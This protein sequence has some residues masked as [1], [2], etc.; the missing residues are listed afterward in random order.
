MVRHKNVHSPQPDPDESARRNLILLV[1]VLTVMLV[2]V[3]WI[4]KMGLSGP[5]PG[6]PAEVA[7]AAPEPP[8]EPVAP[9]PAPT[10]ARVRRSAARKP[11]PAPAPAPRPATLEEHW[12]IQVDSLR[13]S[14]GN[15]IV[16]LRYKILD[17]AKAAQLANGKTPSYII[18]RATGTKLIMPTPP[19]EGAFPPTSHKLVAGKT[20]FSM[21]SN[22]G[23]TLKSGSQ[24][25]V[26]VGG[27]EATNLTLE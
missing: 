9:T 2:A 15:S 1:G 19:K 5:S 14:M 11:A 27:S 13:L 10:V 16:D 6:A 26:V 23:G 17:P 18:D 7:D 20:Y 8:P 3:L 4:V 21:V 24:V 12:G 22:R 25:T